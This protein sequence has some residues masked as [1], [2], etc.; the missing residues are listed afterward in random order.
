MEYPKISMKITELLQ[1]ATL[2]NGKYKIIR[3]LGQGGFGITYEGLQAGLNRKV[4]I[5]EF[6]MKDFCERDADSSH[7]TIVGTEGNRS[8][9]ERFKEKF[10][11]EAQMIAGLEDVPHIIRIY[12]I[13]EENGTAY[14][15]MQYIEGGSLDSKV[16][17]QGALPEPVAVKYVSQMSEALSELHAQRIMHLD[18]KPANVLL[19]GDDVYLIDFG[20]SKHYDDT[21]SATTTTP[22]GRSKGYAPLEQYR[23]GGV[24]EFSPETDI[25]GLG[26]T[27]W[28]LVSGQT[29]PE[30]M[31]LITGGLQRP[32]GISDALWTAISTSMRPGKTERPHSIA[33]FLGLLN[34]EEQPV[35][36]AV[37]DDV[38]TIDVIASNP[39][40]CNPEERIQTFTVNGISFN[41]VHVEGGTFTMGA[42]E[43]QQK[44]DSD[45]K[46]PHQVTLS[47]FSIGETEVTQAL[48]RAV[49]GSNPSYRKGDILPVEMVNWNDCQVFISKLKAL[50]GQPFRLPTEAEWEYAARGG[51]KSRGYQYSGSDNV[52]EV[53]WYVHN[54][55]R[56]THPVKGKLPNELGIYDMCG[57]ILEWCQDWKGSY[58]SS[59]QTNSKGPASG[60]FR[61]IRGGSWYDGAGYC[62][63]AN[64][65]GI[66]PGH[67]YINL[68][69]RLAL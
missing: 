39:E 15:V 64:R 8:L 33:E 13:F 19:R 32:A 59:S 50:T 67:R 62:R 23:Q 58:S 31:E 2:Q 45:E 52:D 68:G 60:S 56:I 11:K 40:D 69:L 20:V 41:M 6:F 34:K 25:Y 38:T 63:V 16:K 3:V 30:A 54:S 4:A 21:G 5:K 66:T 53:A 14:Y 24:Q 9:V 51:S 26:A 7:V 18:I 65:G 55:G 42:T 12:D 47:S 57:N 46:P 28:F 43:E 27:A 49:M 36:Q 61:V 29:P 48:W 10:I 35:V 22:V 37:E 1:D 17:E 44:A